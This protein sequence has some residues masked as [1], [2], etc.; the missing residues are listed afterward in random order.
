LPDFKR[1]QNVLAIIVKVLAEEVKADAGPSSCGVFAWHS[2]SHRAIYSMQNQEQ[3]VP[4]RE[5]FDIA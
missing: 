4:E 2:P 3:K 1:Q 5:L